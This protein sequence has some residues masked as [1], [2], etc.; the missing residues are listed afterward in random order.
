MGWFLDTCATFFG[1]LNHKKK[2]ILIGGWGW[3][4]DLRVKEILCSSGTKPIYF[5][6]VVVI[7]RG[8]RGKRH[9]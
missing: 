8:E 9:M 6:V 2:S 3:G 1:V 5:V 7:A 4:A